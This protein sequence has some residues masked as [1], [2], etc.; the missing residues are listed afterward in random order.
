MKTRQE[1][2]KSKNGITVWFDPIHSHAAT[3]MQDTPHLK[4]LVAEILQ[5]T[6]LTEDLVEF[7]K[8]MGRVVGKTDFVEN[9]PNDE[10]MYA[11]RQNRDVYTPFNKSKIAKPYSGVSVSFAREDDGTYSLRSAW[12]G[13]C[14]SP[15]FPGD[16]T[17]T[18][19]SIPFWTK[20]SLVWGNQA[21]QEDTI[22]SKCPW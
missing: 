13:P 8:D 2:G 9:D 16:P 20:Y 15:P 3:H 12:V 21:V 11:K 22:T 18:A 19:E 14:N 4:D 10:I 7:E 6:E 1:I 5:D 17:E